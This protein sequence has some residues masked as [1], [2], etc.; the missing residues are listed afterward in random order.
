[1]GQRHWKAAIDGRKLVETP[2][3]DLT[4][5]L[6]R[7]SQIPLKSWNNVIKDAVSCEAITFRISTAAMK[8]VLHG[9]TQRAQKVIHA[10]KATDKH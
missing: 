5:S 4:H 3:C 6:T 7:T 1:L 9:P 8:I 2:E 10:A